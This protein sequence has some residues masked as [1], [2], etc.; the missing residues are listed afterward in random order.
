MKGSRIILINVLVLVAL[1]IIGAA[2][3]YY[4]TQST[5]Y[6][7]SQDANVTSASVPAIALQPGIVRTFSA[8]VGQRVTKGQVLGTEALTPVTKGAPSTVNLVAPATGTIAVVDAVPG[9]TVGTGSPLFTEV[10]LGSVYVV[11]NIPET[12]IHS[13]KVGQTVDIT[14]DAE[15][16]VTFHGAVQAISPATQSFFSLIPTAATSGSYTKVTQRVP[17]TISINTAGYTLL[18]G[19]SCEVRIHLN[20]G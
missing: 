5:N 10:K 17:V 11:A 14:V 1:A 15:P 7:T 18:P 2:G 13:L 12:K 9:Q 4:Y 16:G 20:G 6:V 19:E 8:T 3:A